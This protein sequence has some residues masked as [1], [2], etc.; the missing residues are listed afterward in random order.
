MQKLSFALVQRNL[1]TL[2][3]SGLILLGVAYYTFYLL[4]AKTSSLE[5]R[6]YRVLARIGV[7]L[8]QQLNAQRKTNEGIEWQLR[9]VAKTSSECIDESYVRANWKKISRAWPSPVFVSLNGLTEDEQQHKRQEGRFTTLAVVGDQLVFQDTVTFRTSRCPNAQKVQELAW[10]VPL[11][12]VAGNLMRPDAF[13]YFFI[14]DPKSQRVLYSS[15]ASVLLLEPTEHMPPAWVR[16]S[17]GLYTSTTTR[18]TLQ[19]KAHYLF[20]TPR[21]VA[22]GGTWL[23]CGAVRTKV[24]D[25]ERQ[26]VSG[27]VMELGLLILMLGMLSLPFLKVTFMGPR[28]RLS[29]QDVLRLGA[30]LVLG[31]GLLLIGLQSLTLRHWLEEELTERQ[32]E[33]LS[34]MVSSRLTTEIRELSIILQKTD[35][36]LAHNGSIRRELGTRPDSRLWYCDLSTMEAGL[37]AKE[38]QLLHRQPDSS[39][40]MLWLNRQGQAQ[41]VLGYKTTDYLASLAMRDYFQAVSNA[42]LTYQ[43]LSRASES[44]FLGSVVSYHNSQ[45]VA[46]LARGSQWQ[47]QSQGQQPTVCL[48][49]TVLRCLQQPVLPPGFSFCLINQRGEVLFHSNPRLSLSENLLSDC[50]PATELRAAMFTRSS[51]VY[52]AAYQGRDSRLWVRP[53][54]VA[55]PGLYLVTI[56][57]GDYLRSWQLQTSLGALRLLVGFWLLL[58]ALTIAWRR[59]ANP[60]ALSARIRQSFPRLWPRPIYAGRY[61]TIALVHLAAVS[62]LYLFSSRLTP[63]GQVMG[64]L[65]LPFWL[66]GLTAY[67]LRLK[68]DGK[69][70]YEHSWL[71]LIGAVLAVN[72]LAGHYLGQRDEGLLLGFQAML[73]TIIGLGAY[74]YQPTQSAEPQSRWRVIGFGFA[75]LMGLAVIIQAANY[76]D[77]GKGHRLLAFQLLFLGAVGLVTF[78]SNWRVPFGHHPS[79]RLGYSAMLLAWLTV[80]GIVPALYCYQIANHSERVVQMRQTHLTLLR[81]LES[82]RVLTQADSA[83][84]YWRFYAGT[85]WLDNKEASRFPRSPIGPGV[86]ANRKFFQWLHYDLDDEN[87]GRGLPL[88]NA[89]ETGIPEPLANTTDTGIPEPAATATEDSKTNARQVPKIP[90]SHFDGTAYLAGQWWV[91]LPQSLWSP[92]AAST[93]YFSQDSCAAGPSDT[94]HKIVLRSAADALVSGYGLLLAT[95][96]KSAQML[97]FYGLI[98]A[99]FL[100]LLALLAALIHFLAQQCFMPATKTHLYP[101]RVSPASPVDYRG[102]VHRLIITPAAST[103][104]TL[105][106]ELQQEITAGRPARLSARNL[107]QQAPEQWE[108]WL[109]KELQQQNS[110]SRV[111][112]EE[113]DFHAADASLTERKRWVIEAL[114]DKGKEIVVLSR[115]HPMA[116]V[117]CEH[118]LEP[119]C[120]VPDHV[121]QREAGTALLDA[122]GYFRAEYLSLQQL[123]AASPLVGLTKPQQEA[124]NRE[125][126]ALPFLKQQ[127]EFLLRQMKASADRGQHLEAEHIVSLMERLAQFHY[128]SLWRLLGPEEQFY[129]YDLAQDGLVNPHNR[130]VMDTLLQKGYLRFN[131]H[132]RLLLLNDSFRQFAL[133]ALQ[134]QRVATFEELHRRDS[135]WA[136]WQLPLML[137]LTSGILFV[138]V[139]QRAAMS[140]AEQLLTAFVTLLPLIGRLLSSF[141]APGQNKAEART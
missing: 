125:C 103:L 39:D 107:A 84:H 123:P 14:V 133:S 46:I 136:A 55:Q 18:L 96:A 140:G 88:A 118:P 70:V 40:V 67:L 61:W 71:V 87:R 28:E 2:A 10:S 138:F 141:S 98:P 54:T 23:L 25:A 115:C 62:W 42:P 21:R 50:E 33:K 131:R 101:P 95:K 99:F 56:A 108:R 60:P 34:D 74:L 43:G 94:D 52:E 36:A 66:F 139:T 13:S 30:A 77:S 57:D 134:Q 22:G 97:D 110:P 8:S 32:L 135:T 83:N 85:R 69:L 111:V 59:L 122:L 15:E 9:Q 37:S 128:R 117:H 93:R 80:L 109:N 35:A 86:K 68:A 24:F 51:Q 53:L 38:L 105:P 112:F 49:G 58:L 120:T 1:G 11:D 63:L 92:A 76:L 12:S 126:N 104:E 47:P 3:L 79:Y 91:N 81:Q 116:L 82:K 124:V 20:V 48:L 73:A 72:I 137:V 17:S 130:H 129:L 127:R 75:W 113:L 114:L 41:L 64:L 90:K 89:T 29:H 45:P 78:L 132:G 26:A 16:D 106:V 100:L 121:R 4:P 19:G 44:T 119:P 65:L 5:S 27:G 31:S 7:N 102:Q 6:Y